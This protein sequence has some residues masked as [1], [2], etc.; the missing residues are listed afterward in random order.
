MFSKPLSEE[1]FC[2]RN[3]NEENIPYW[4]CFKSD[5]YFIIRVEIFFMTS[6]K[7]KVFIYFFSMSLFLT[8][9]WGSDSN[10]KQRKMIQKI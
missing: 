3:P 5:N 9:H 7:T 2:K 8:N 4:Q 10:S 6:I 1:N